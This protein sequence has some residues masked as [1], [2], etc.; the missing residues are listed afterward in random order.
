MTL[1]KLYAARGVGKLGDTG[2]IVD[3]ISS[4]YS[5]RNITVDQKGQGIRLPVN[6]T[7]KVLDTASY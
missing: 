7:E 1:P 5:P 4:Q 2:H 3:S 6:L